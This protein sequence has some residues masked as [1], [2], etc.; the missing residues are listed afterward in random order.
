MWLYDNII[1]RAVVIYNYIYIKE[2]IKKQCIKDGY[3]VSGFLMI[4][5]SSL[6][7]PGIA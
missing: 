5:L 2:Y 3:K 6:S 7:N 4:T 1:I